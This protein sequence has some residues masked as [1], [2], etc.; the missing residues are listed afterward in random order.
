MRAACARCRPGARHDPRRAL[1]VAV[2]A[3]L[4]VPAVAQTS[5]APGQAP[6]ARTTAQAATAPTTRAAQRPAPRRAQPQRR[7]TPAPA[8]AQAAHPRGDPAPVPNRDME[9]PRAREAPGPTARLDPT[10]IDPNE[11]RYGTAVDRN[12]LQA[13]EDRLL[14]QPAPGA[15]LRLPFAY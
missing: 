7:A 4:A 5:P 14:R 2:L 13:R 15:R 8:P 11:P 6:S 9:P 1:L 12:N 3:A 10:L